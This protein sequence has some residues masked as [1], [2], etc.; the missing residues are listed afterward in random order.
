MTSRLEARLEDLA[1]RD[2]IAREALGANGEKLKDA[3]AE[4]ER[5]ERERTGVPEAEIKGIFDWYVWDEYATGAFENVES[6][7]LRWVS[8]DSAKARLLEYVPDPVAPFA[9]T[10]SDGRRIKPGRFLTDGG[11]VP[12][13][14]TLVSG[15]DRFGY[16][17]AYLIHDW[18]YVLHHCGQL[19]P[20]VTQAA[21][22][23]A[24]LEALK[25]MMTGG[26]I[27][28][29]R[30][31]FWAIKTALERFAASYWDADTPCSLEV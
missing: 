1:L 14:A 23:R 29:S 3:I 12:D 28:E 6:I 17:P 19:P 31:D 26:L 27:S 20:E 7:N 18:D 22:D 25:T 9:F 8:G 16:L 10:T 24:L 21:A 5:G 30:K 4:K 11:T 2:R 15:I 13:A